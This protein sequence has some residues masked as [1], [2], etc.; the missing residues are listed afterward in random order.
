MTCSLDFL[1]IS[2][3]RAESLGYPTGIKR[4]GR[5]FSG[6]FRALAMKFIGLGVWVS[7]TNPAL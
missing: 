5:S 7:A 6:L 4:N 3:T 1:N 2:G